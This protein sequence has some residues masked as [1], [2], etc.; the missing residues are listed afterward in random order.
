MPEKDPFQSI[1]ELLRS[2]NAQPLVFPERVAP[3]T[4]YDLNYRI[5]I[6]A[7]TF[8]LYA[9]AD[10]F[11]GRRIR[12][13]LLKLLQFLAVRPWLIPML[14][15]WE[16]AEDNPQLS[17]LTSQKERR[18]FLSD[19]MHDHVVEYLVARQIL[20]RGPSHLSLDTKGDVLTSL[21]S[22]LKVEA[23][24]E[25]E[26]RALSEMKDIKITNNMLEGW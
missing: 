25:N 11:A 13:A 7:L 1:A 18:G 16:R 2:G 21:A 23:L 22:A 4:V 3:S 8:D 15:K 14:V 10:L 26:R 24:F 5:A 19:L 12:T 9:K 17:V 20:K 6:I